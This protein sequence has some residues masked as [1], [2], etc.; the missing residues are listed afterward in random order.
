MR[1]AFLGAA[2]TVTG[3]KFLVTAGRRRVLVDCGLFQGFKQLR[4]RNWAPL[5]VDPASIHAVVVTHAHVDHSGY[6]PVLVKQGFS[7]PVF[8]SGGTRDLCGI[9]LPDAGFLQEEEAQYANRHGYSKH[10]P[11]LPLFTRLDAQRALTHIIPIAYEKRHDLGDGLEVRLDPAGHLLGASLVTLTFAGATIT[12]S[13][14]LGRPRDP[15]MRPPASIAAPDYLV[16]EST[17]GDR[18][19]DPTDP[20]T[21]LG[22]VINRTAGRGG[23]VIIP[24]FAVG[25]AQTMLY[26]IERLKSGGKIPDI[27]VFLNSPMAV[28][29]TG[30]YMAAHREHRLTAAQCEAVSRTARFVTDVDA[31]KRLNRMDGPMIIIS[32]SGMATGG[33]VIHHLKAFAP[34]PKNTIL[35]VGYQVP[36]TRGA[37]LVAGARSVKIH[38][39]HVPVNAEVVAMNNVSAHADAD[40]LMAWLRAVPAPPRLTFLVHGEPAAADALRRRI[41]HELG[42]PCRV[43]EH[44]E[45]ARLA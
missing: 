3:S 26:Y 23:V 36:G 34:D 25:R 29:A 2:G 14:D 41:E 18:V 43:P 37:A 21:A 10:A 44:R 38:G 40:E 45:V 28:D 27:P 39:E 22:T 9:L 16:V 5:P 7:G 12:F 42:W 35:F 17:Y 8:C 33:R 15:I 24:A 20:E 1:V 31:S 19:H 13:G 32:A 6:L 4:L 30:L 11:A